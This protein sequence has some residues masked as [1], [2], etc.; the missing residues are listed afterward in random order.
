MEK[1][2]ER[3]N[4]GMDVLI[5]I[6]NNKLRIKQK[7]TNKQKDQENITSFPNFP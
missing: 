2:L 1:E 5:K 4:K 7:Q 6:E 3:S